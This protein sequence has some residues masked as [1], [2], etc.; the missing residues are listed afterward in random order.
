MS[1][2]SAAH[3]SDEFRS[4]MKEWIEIKKIIKEARASLKKLTD[5]EKNLATFLKGFMK[6][7]KIDTCNLRK[8]KVKY[9]SKQGKKAIT[10][11]T[12]EQGLLEFFDGD[13]GRADAA[14]E[15]IERKRE[16]KDTQSLRV[17]GLKNKTDDTSESPPSSP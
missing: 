14:I 13:K 15:C 12:I 11:K 1:E 2:E 8:G 4:S 5:R 3:I 9:T 7:N 16:I 10:K 17:S 6:S